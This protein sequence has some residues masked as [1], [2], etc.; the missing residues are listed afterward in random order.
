M[1]PSTS[2]RA[3]RL[4][5][6]VGAVAPVDAS[7]WKTPAQSS[8]QSS[9]FWLLVVAV[10]V[11]GRRWLSVRSQWRSVRPGGNR[12]GSNPGVPMST[13][14]PSR[15]RVAR[16]SPSRSKITRWP[17][18]SMPE[19]RARRG[20][21]AARSYSARSVSRTTIPSP[22]A[23]VVRL[24]HALHRIGSSIR[25]RVVHATGR[26]SPIQRRARPGPGAHPRTDHGMA[27]TTRRRRGI[28]PP[29]VGSAA[30]LVTLPALMQP[31][32]TSTA[33]R[34][35][36]E[37]PDPLD[38]RVPAALGAPVRVADAHAERR[39]LATHLADRC[40]RTR[41]T[42]Q[43][44]ADRV[45]PRDCRTGRADRRSDSP[46]LARTRARRRLAL[47]R[48]PRSPRSPPAV[49]TLD[50]PR[51]RRPARA[52]DRGLPRMRSPPTGRRSTGSTC[53]RCPTATPA[54][55]WP[56][57][58]SRWCDE[59]DGR[60][61][62]P[63]RRVQG[64]QPRL[65]HGRPGQLGRDPVADPAGPR[66]R[67]CA[68]AGELDGA[69]AGRGPAGRVRRGVRRGDAAGRG[70][71]PHRRPRGGRGGRGGRRRRAG[72]AGRGRSR[73]ARA[74]G[75]RRAGAARPSMLPVLAEAGVVDAG[76]AGLP[77]AARRAAPRRRRPRRARAR[78]VAEGAGAGSDARLVTAHRRRRTTSGVG[79]PAL[80]GH[81]LPRGARR[82]PSRRSRTCG[83][84]SAT[85]S[86]WSAA[87]ASG[88]ATST[89]TTSAPPSRPPSTSAGPA[90]SGSPTCSSRSRRSAGSARPPAPTA[91]RS[92]RTSPSRSRT[93]VVAVAAGDGIRRIFHSLGVQGIVAGGQSMNPSTAEL[94]EAVE[95]VPAD[96]GRDPAE[97]QEH[98]PG[99]RAGRRPDRQG[100]AGRAHPGRRRG[101]RRA[102]GLRPRGRRP[103]RTPRRWP[104][105]PPTSWPARS[106]GPCATRTS[107][108]GPIARGR[109]P[110]H[111]PR[112]HPGRRRPPR[113]APP[114]ACSTCWST[115]EHEIVTIIEGEGATA[116]R[117]P[118][119]HR[120]AGRAPARRRGR[121]PPRRPAALPLPL[122]HRVGGRDQPGP[123]TLGGARRRAGHRAEGRRA[124]RKAE[125]LGAARHRAPCSTC[126]PTTPAATSTAPARPRS[127]DLEVGEEAMVLA[128][129]R[130]GRQ[131]RRTRGRPPKTLV[132]RRRHRRHRPPAGHASSTSRGGSGSC[133]RA[134]RRSSS[135]SSSIFTGRR[136][137]T[138]PVVDLIGDQTGRIVPVYPQSEKAG[139]STW[140]IGDWVGEALR[141]SRPRGFA[142]PV[143]EP[144]AR[145]LRPGRPDARRSTASTPPS[146][147]PHKD[148]ARR[149]LVFD[150]LLRVQLALVLRKRASSGPTT[151][152]R[153]T[154]SPGALRR[155]G[156]TSGCPSSSPAPSSG[157]SPR[158]RA[159]LAAPHPMHRLLQGDVGRG[160]DGGGGQRAARRGAGRPPGRAH[161]AH[162]G[163]GRAARPRASGRCST[164]SPC[165]DDGDVLFGERPAAGRAADQPDDGGRAAPAPRP[166]WPT[167]RSTS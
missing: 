72:L 126:S 100:R 55:T 118:A 32:Q 131:S 117:H 80:R 1:P 17:W 134:P 38:V 35:V 105:R 10:M 120:V 42:S 113:R 91:S 84:A 114:P 7:G 144:G 23:G 12:S 50:A 34:A 66:R 110:G 147:W 30:T 29:A 81:V 73:P 97:Q 157:P 165:A 123:I 156:S 148:A 69:D 9:S 115:D 142:D 130:A 71:D 154:T 16:P 103:T 31:V 138:N 135:A 152:H 78:R 160:Q 56:S 3:R 128:T 102:A 8:T 146:R 158:S 53:T 89:P 82:R 79:R 125:A 129:R 4:V 90:R 86:W 64:D 92:R 46:A 19:D 93:A 2:S 153:A 162:R 88:T 94:L 124:E 137:M 108:A 140:D 5:L 127:R 87:T 37:G 143:P 58:S 11:L 85:R 39:V 167:A 70:H 44:R 112:R 151:G 68:E 41:L 149:R 26:L 52:V 141:R 57:R 99:G 21:P 101:L 163:A 25:G 74:P 61:R 36:H 161:G 96:A 116:G 45:G 164:G 106:P 109:L 75:G 136:Q 48:G 77:A 13:S 33:W 6:L 14:E 60:R 119:H 18:R 76:G 49:T 95:A 22:R 133:R 132:D 166:A 20:R 111:R 43:D 63:G 27:H 145:P 150:E 139:L 155:R 65:A 51:R 159:D 15:R 67:A 122:R 121:G 54:P 47:G 83:P 98:H 59:L 104:R 107:D 40:H 28:G 62:R 24:D